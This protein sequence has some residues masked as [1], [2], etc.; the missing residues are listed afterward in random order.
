M[1]RYNVRSRQIVDIVGEIRREKLKISP[2]FQRKLIWRI[3]HKI[4]FI[5]T[6]LLGYPFPEIFIAQGALDI[7]RM[8]FTTSVVDGQ[9]RLNSIKE[10]IDGVF[11]V[12]GKYYSE[13]KP[14]EKEAFLKY[15]VAIIEL[16]LKHDDPVV[17]EIFQRLNRTFYSLTYIEKL[18]TEYAPSELMLLAKLISGEL[19]IQNELVEEEEKANEEEEEEEINSPDFDPSIPTEFITWGQ[20]V[21][22]RNIK[23]LIV[24]SPIFTSYQISRQVHLMFCLNIIG[25]IIENKLYNR[26]IRKR[27]LEK[28]SENLE[29]KDEII[30]NLEL[31]AG[32]ILKMKLKKD[33]YWHNKANMF[34]L[35]IALYKNIDKFD[36][37]EPQIIKEALEYFAQDIPAD[38]KLAAKEGVNNTKERLIRDSHL[39]TII[40][41][42]NDN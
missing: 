33:S 2:F 1:L 23:K 7:E 11:Q 4:D 8:T 5:K 26:N 24:E 20:N 9:Q 31:V 39:Q 13:L 25:T 19:K 34:S 14:K 32:K 21:Q 28:Y 22:V 12:D 17:K 40:D 42:L 6:I 30:T 29:V 10:F 37:L 16:D 27:M 38:Y 41:K 35:I 3:G 36:K 15:E 18:S